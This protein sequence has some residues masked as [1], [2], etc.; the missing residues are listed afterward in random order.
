MDLN[1]YQKRAVSTAIYPNQGAN[2]VYP[3][4]G[5]TG[6]AGE[7]AEQIKKALR[8]DKGRITDARWQSLQKELGD[9]LWYL[10]VLAHEL[11]MSLDSVARTNLEKLAQRKERG[12]LRGEGSDR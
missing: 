5:L 12:T 9:V 7:V 4:L 8:D 1:E 10:A 6:E 11:S 3:V 2:F